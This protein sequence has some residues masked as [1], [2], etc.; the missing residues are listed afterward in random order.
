MSSEGSAFAGGMVVGHNDRGCSGCDCAMDTS[1]G[2]TRELF[3]VPSDTT[4]KPETLFLAESREGHEPF[5]DLVSE[6]GTVEAVDIIG[7][8]K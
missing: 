2:W 6:Q 8:V 1:R 7:G 5:S 4:S 3:S